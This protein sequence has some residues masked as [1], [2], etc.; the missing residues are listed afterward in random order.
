MFDTG[1]AKL[2]EHL[3]LLKVEA[4]LFPWLYFIGSMKY[5]DVAEQIALKISPPV[6]NPI[7]IY[8]PFS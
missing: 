3:T 1:A 6:L 7:I 2:L 4:F 5:A 8:V